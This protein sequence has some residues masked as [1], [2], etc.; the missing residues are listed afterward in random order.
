MT[1]KP[2]DSQTHRAIVELLP[3]Y[4]NGTLPLNE[5]EAVAA[6]LAECPDCLAESETLADLRSA[7]A[8]SN[9]RLP[10]PSDRQLDALLSRI[11]KEEPART[12]RSFVPRIRNWWELLPTPARWALIAQA[13]AIVALACASV[14]LWRHARRMEDDAIRERQRAEA[15]QQTVPPA[16]PRQT[17]TPDEQ[18]KTLSGP[19]EKVAG[20]SVKITVVFH[21]G[22]SAKE[23]QALLTSIKANIVSGPTLAGVYVLSIDVPPG[24]DERKVVTD[25]LERLRGRTDVV[26]FAEP[27]R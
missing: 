20:P 14:A 22:A 27:H 15:L 9:E 2:A 7:V 26:Q 12:R 21:E 23:T 8:E 1:R 19:P 3:W 24:A 18:Y 16:G 10:S 11:A 13:A 4:V 5:R 25:S 6:H 17:P